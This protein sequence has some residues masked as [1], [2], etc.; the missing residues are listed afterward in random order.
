MEPQSPPT[1]DQSDAPMSLTARIACV[2][3][4]YDILADLP[5]MGPTLAHIRGE[6][7]A[8]KTG[9]YDERQPFPLPGEQAEVQPS[10]M[11]ADGPAMTGTP[12][13]VWDSKK[14]YPDPALLVYAAGYSKL[15]IARVDYAGA[16]SVLRALSGEGLRRI[17]A[18]MATKQWRHAARALKEKAVRGALWLMTALKGAPQRAWRGL[19]SWMKWGAGAAA[20]GAAGAG[21]AALGAAGAQ[22]GVGWGWIPATI[23]AAIL[24]QWSKGA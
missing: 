5:G 11:T 4:A 14:E 12:A 3:Q 16:V 20:G 7:R 24:W 23:I 9:V 18:I 10:A 1:P 13:I 6:F 22:S 2:I 21:A 15:A 19:P 8:W 17:A